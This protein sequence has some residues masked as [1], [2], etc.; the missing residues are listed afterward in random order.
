MI[1]ASSAE[2]YPQPQ[3]SS[4]FLCFD[5]PIHPLPICGSQLKPSGSHHIGSISLKLAYFL[6]YGTSPLDVP[7][8]SNYYKSLYF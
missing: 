3:T 5:L 6:F 2:C 8:M 1:T 4:L 7:M